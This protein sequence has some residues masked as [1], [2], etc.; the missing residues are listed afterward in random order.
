MRRR[1]FIAASVAAFAARAGTPIRRPDPSEKFFWADNLL[2]AANDG[3]ERMDSARYRNTVRNREDWNRTRDLW[4]IGAVRVIHYEPG[5]H[6]CALGDATNA[7]S[8]RKVRRFT[9]EIVYVPDH[10][11]L[12][13]FDRVATVN[14]AFRKAWPLHSVNEPAVVEDNRARR[15]GPGQ[16]FYTPGDDH[17]GPWG[18]G[19]NWPLDPPEGGPLPEDPRLRHMWKVFYGEDFSEIWKSNRAN[20]VPGA[21]RLEVSPAKPAEEDLF[22]HL[23]EIG[24]RGATG[25]RR[26]T[27]L[28]GIN[29]AGA[30]VENGSAVLFSTA[31][32]V[33]DQGEATLPELHCDSLLVTSLKPDAIHNVTFFGPEFGQS[34]SSPRPGISVGGSRPR[35]N[36]QG[37]LRLDI[38][39]IGNARFRIAQI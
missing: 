3:G 31:G 12:F 5:Q 34:T 14:P 25:G 19:E 21:W 15:G 35:A 32:A 1:E 7:Y 37:I 13:V 23:L 16:E 20:V 9:R 29:F 27:L 2:P 26:V 30:A 38:R 18:S 17:G 4:D 28:D 8:R 36:S 33:V 10:R 22:L 24:D 11:A 6:H 39:G